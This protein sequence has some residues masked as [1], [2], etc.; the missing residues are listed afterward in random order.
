MSRWLAV[1]V[2][3][4]V[5]AAGVWVTGAVVTDDETVARGLTGV[6]LA[7]A[8]LSALY[9]AWRWRRLAWPVLGTFVVV[10]GGISAFLLYTS[11]VDRVVDETVVV[12]DGTP[13]PSPSTGS[14]PATGPTA[15]PAGNR[16]L[17]VGE[18]VDGAHPTSGTATLIDTAEGDRVVTLTDFETDPGP[19]LRLYL[20]P[21]GNDGVSGG[22][23]L[24]ALKGNKGNQQYPV[25]ASFQSAPMGLQ[26]VVWCRAFTVAFGSATLA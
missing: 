25:P 12:A 2:V 21:K 9:V 14:G 19:D 7:V 5:V 11:S 1:P 16:A 3:A 23:D 18:F 4:A 15:S 24:G 10:A 8:G 22:V 17:G 6:W 20:V 13:S 26:V